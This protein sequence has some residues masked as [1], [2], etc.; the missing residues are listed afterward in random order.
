MSKLIF[1]PVILFAIAQNI[2]SK[3][4]TIWNQTDKQGQKQGFWR[5]SYESGKTRYIGFFKD[6]RPL[7]E[8]K[9]FYEDGV[10]MAI[11][12]FL[13]NKKSRA[14]LFYK[15]GELAGE[16]N[17][18]ESM[19]DSVWKYYSYYDK[20]LK[21]EEN[22]IKGLKEG[23]SKKYYTTNKVAEEIE[24]HNNQ[25]HGP[26]KQYYDDGSPKLN[27]NYS[28][29]KRYGSFIT[30]YPT[31]K[32]EIKGNFENNLMQ[33]EWIYY[34]E[35]GNIK[36]KVVYVNGIAQNA[37]ELQK[38]DDEYFKLIDNNKGKFPEPDENNIML[39]K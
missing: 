5:V 34:D 22:Y 11:Q 30:Y 24:W 23:Y 33:G 29:D 28:K 17:F 10:I 13:D 21:M 4:D 27:A 19:K 25:K 15:N 16:G 6:N 18:I 36:S 20:S 39:N 14:K 31:G 3:S 2:A 35:N 26:W 32:T 9:R 37:T 38:K 8:M 1:I 7:G 12:Y